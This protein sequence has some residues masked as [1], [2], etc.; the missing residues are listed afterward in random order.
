MRRKKQESGIEYDEKLLQHIAPIGNMT[1]YNSYCRTGTGYEACVHIFSLPTML[2]DF[3]MT[4]I[5]NF[6]NSVA[7]I[8]IGTMDEVKVKQNLNKAIEE[9]ASRMRFA[10]DYSAYYDAKSR[11]EEM[12]R[13]YEEISSLGEVMKSI[14]MRIFVTAKT[15][16]TMEERVAKTI[17]TLEGNNYR[18]AIFL[19]EAESEWKSIYQS[20]EEQQL[21]PHALSGFPMKA[22]LLAAGNAYHYSCLEDDGGDFLGET[23]CG[24]NVLYNEWMLTETRVNASAIVVGNQRFGKSTLLKLR[25][26]S[27]VLR[28]DYVR[29]IDVVGEFTDE[30]RALAG[31]TLDMS[32]Y[33]INL[34]EIFRS[35]ENEEMNYARH[36]AKLRTSYKFLCPEADGKEINDF[37]EIVEALYKSW[38]LKPNGENQITGLPAKAYPI[39]GDL[40]EYVDQEIEAIVGKKWRAGEKILVERKL[41][42][43]DRI[44]SNLRLI[45]STYGSVFNGHTSVD[46]MKDVKA[47][48]YDLSKLKDMDANIFDLELFNILSL[49]WDDAVTN[50]AIM[51]KL[52]EEKKIALE[53]VAHTILYIDESH[54][55]VNAQKPYAL[56][57]LSIYLREGPK[58]FSSIWLASQ[59][60]RDYVPEGS[61]TENIEKLKLLFEL[62]QYKFIFKQDRNVI[63]LIDQIFGNAL[64]PRQRERIPLYSRGQTTLLISGD[65]TIDFKVYLSKEDEALFKGGA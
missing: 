19:N 42:N 59:S 14:S 39:F 35:G 48:S 62:T 30:I 37:T 50:G 51:K 16:Q 33:I 12:Q 31:R 10:K 2:D 11:E 21:E 47:L 6:Q 17:K 26:K 8:S 46:N 1:P 9:Q 23:G 60:I 41:I 5:C 15:K 61:T 29:V 22:T 27:R 20:M 4:D 53:D 55:S 65:Q 63:P 45:T 58:Y 34:L 18:A 36:L 52:W 24:G 7:T 3:W 64:T 28:G 56:D 49:S 25:I 43:L 40:L 13:L 38:G 44:R 32:R 57:L 54:R